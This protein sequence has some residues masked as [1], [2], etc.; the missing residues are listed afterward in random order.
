MSNF[1]EE[2]EPD[3]NNP[4]EMHTPKIVSADVDGSMMAKAGSMVSYKGDLSFTGKASAEGG[5]LGFMKE[6]A[7][8]EGSP[9]MEIEGTGRVHLA[10]YGKRI[11]LVDLDEN[12]Q[13]TV[14]GDDVLAF[15]PTIDYEI[16]T[17]SGLSGAQSG[18]L[19]NVFLSGPGVVAITTHGDPLVLEPPVKTD[20]AATVAW[21]GSLEPST[22]IDTGISDIVGQ[23]SGETFQMKFEGDG[24]V[25]VQS[26]EEM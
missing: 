23:S 17:M 12:D 1:L 20:P 24:F 10:D 25:I 18:G 4:Y 22:D 26:V 14:N 13:I 6:A 5:V 2:H 19:V 7:T 21:D 8:S 11:Q 15:G 16:N 9:V 3:Q